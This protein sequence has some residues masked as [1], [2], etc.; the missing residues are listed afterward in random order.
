MKRIALGIVGMIGLFVLAVSGLALTKPQTFRVQRD[1]TIAAPAEVIFSNIE[2]FH[3]W[4]AWSPYE[5]LEPTIKKSFSGPERGLGASYSWE[6]QKVGSGK[7]TITEL[8][9]NQRV[10]IRLEFTA[11]FEATDTAVFELTPQPAGTQVSWSMTGE[12]SFFGKVVSIFADTDAMI[13]KDFVS[14]LLALK[15]VSEAK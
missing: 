14:G 4:E 8:A 5:K 15:Q 3:R 2:D 1:V 13:G 11:P 7:M 10:T 6:G 9:P 12:N